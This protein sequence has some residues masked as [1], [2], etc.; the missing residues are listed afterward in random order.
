[1]KNPGEKLGRELNSDK[2]RHPNGYQTMTMSS[3]VTMGMQTKTTKTY[4][5][6]H[7]TD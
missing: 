7:P 4:L 3:L 2:R 1:M 6:T 5:C